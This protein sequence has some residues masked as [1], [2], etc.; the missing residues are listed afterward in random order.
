[1]LS[2]VFPDSVRGAG[3]MQILLTCYA[4]FCLWYPWFLRNWIIIIGRVYSAAFA[5]HSWIHN[6]CAVRMCCHKSISGHV[7]TTTTRH[8]HQQPYG[9]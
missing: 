7:T 6:H 4:F 5:G 1:M 8:G 3:H 2:A 9:E